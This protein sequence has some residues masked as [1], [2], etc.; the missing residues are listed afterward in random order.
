QGLVGSGQRVHPDPRGVW[1]R[2]RVR[3]RAQVPRDPALPRCP[4]LHQPHPVLSGRA[5]P[6]PAALVLASAVIRRA[7]CPRASEFTLGLLPFAVNEDRRSWPDVRYT[8]ESST[9][10]LTSWAANGP[11]R[12][13]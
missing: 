2:R 5:R 6:R 11:S 8:T 4:D 10:R 7:R 9:R 12:A 13:I 1:L 3:R